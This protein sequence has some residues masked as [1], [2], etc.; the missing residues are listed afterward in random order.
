MR[1]N[2]T[3]RGVNLGGWLVLEKW[4][5]PSLFAGTTAR[6]EYTFMQTPGAAE[7][8]EQHRQTFI[9][10]A[11]FAW[12]KD[13]GVN[14]V[15][16]PIGYWIF[17]GDGPFTAAVQYLDWAVQMADKYQLKVLID[18][19]GLQG[20]QNGNDHSGRIGR[21]AWYD[22]ADCREASIVTLETI[23]KRYY[24]QPAVWGIEVI[25][26]PKPK[27]VQRTLRR[28]YQEAYDRLCAV[29][30]PGTVIV[31]HD[32]FRPRRLSGA[33]KARAKYPVVMDIHWYQFGSVWR[34]WEKLENYFVRIM[35]R[36]RLVRKL[37][38]KQP[39]I[40]GE[41]SLVLTDKMLDGRKRYDAQAAFKTHGMVQLDAYERAL[42]WFY[43][44]YKTEGRG[45]WHF[46]SLIEDGVISFK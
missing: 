11:D 3:I 26:E 18:L 32:A 25:N 2:E 36:P 7:K 8:I 1:T 40:I 13:N 46:R 14:A 34:T 39:V 29:A 15:R 31:F 28:F 9:T 21:S 35:K 38:R 43:W 33:L 10:E 12:L 16:I 41:W 45:I 20:S 4:M 27:L 37:Q 22:H 23:A 5:T 42:G 24:D 19:H 44:T 6:D 30:R 17:E